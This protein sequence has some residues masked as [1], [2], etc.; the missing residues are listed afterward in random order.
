LWTAIFLKWCFK[1]AKHS[2]RNMLPK[3][4]ILL[5][6]YAPNERWH[7]EL[8]DFYAATK[9]QF[10][11]SFIIVNDGS[12][13]QRLLKQMEDL[14]LADIPVQFIS[15]AANRGKGYALRTGAATS[16]CG[17]IVYTDLDFP[18]TTESVVAVLNA[19]VAGNADVVAGYRNQDYYLSKMSF[20][21]K[22]LS[23]SFRFF[24][25]QILR[26]PVSDTQCGLKGFNDKGKAVFLST[27][28]DRYLFDFEFIFQCSRKS[29]IVL[30]TV[31][32][33]L[34][35]NVVFS[36]MKLKILLQESLNLLKVLFRAG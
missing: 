18:F 27:T 7:L 19:L 3:A 21:R 23:R 8:K 12:D 17:Y 6:C 22:S 29:S 9:G 36:N 25:K 34:K 30:T 24:L 11:L 5:P 32:V 10:D 13:S 31:P 16:R 26:M 15:Y 20:F 28:I 14:K 2:A 35:E 1:E 4:D 33:Q